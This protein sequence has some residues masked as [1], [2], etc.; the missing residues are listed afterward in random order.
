MRWAIPLNRSGFALDDKKAA[1]P[2]LI[3]SC[4]DLHIV[5]HPQPVASGCLPCRSPYLSTC[6]TALTK[7]AGQDR[8]HPSKP[9]NGSLASFTQHHTP[10][11][12][13]PPCGRL[14]RCSEAGGSQSLIAYAI[15][16]G[17]ITT[18]GILRM[19]PEPQS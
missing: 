13:N 18:V 7:R 5:Y 4:Y 2:K 19:T 1:C 6:S 10:K 8:E 9:G 3:P 16:R 14:S 15:S 12:N 11:S 17:M